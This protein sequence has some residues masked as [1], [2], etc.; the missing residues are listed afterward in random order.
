MATLTETEF[1]VAGLSTRGQDEDAPTAASTSE[2]CGQGS[3]GER[4]PSNLVEPWVAHAEGVQHVVGGIHQ[5]SEPLQIVLADGID[6]GNRRRTEGTNQGFVD[7]RVR[8]E[9]VANPRHLGRGIT[10]DPRG[11]D[12]EIKTAFEFQRN[13][14]PVAGE[15]HDATV[16]GHVGVDSGGSPVKDAFSFRGSAEDSLRGGVRAES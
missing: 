1:N 16:A 11:H 7:L 15:L 12:D 6:A 8:V 2:L 10:R 9:P 4:M 13:C 14:A 5:V 3:R